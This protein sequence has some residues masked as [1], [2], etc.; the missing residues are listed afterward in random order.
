[1]GAVKALFLECELLGGVVDPVRSFNPNF[2]VLEDCHLISTSRVR[3]KP[4]L[5]L[6]VSLRLITTQ[7]RLQSEASPC[8]VCGGQSGTGTGFEY[9]GFPL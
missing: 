4:I 3:L 8:G 9:F 5:V 6:E 2:R 7:A 1:M